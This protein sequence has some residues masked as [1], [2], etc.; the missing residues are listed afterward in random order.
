LGAAFAAALVLRRFAGAGAVAL[1]F[2][3]MGHP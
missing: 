1:V 2:F 3:F